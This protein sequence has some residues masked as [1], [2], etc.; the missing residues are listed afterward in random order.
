MWT[1]QRI[2]I[3]DDLLCRTVSI[4]SLKLEGRENYRIKNHPFFIQRVL[5]FYDVRRAQFGSSFCHFQEYLLQRSGGNWSVKRVQKI[6]FSKSLLKITKLW[7]GI[8]L[9][10]A[11]VEL[12]SYS[13]STWYNNYVTNHKH[14]IYT[15]NVWSW[16]H[17]IHQ[18][19]T[20][21]SIGSIPPPTQDPKI[22]PEVTPPPPKKKST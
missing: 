14:T 3:Y 15:V 22:E 4:V 8:L 2:I 11:L 21:D 7:I 10:G 9:S 12:Y 19:T 20:I 18:T 13:S 5:Q 1:K 16:H 17:S 6:W